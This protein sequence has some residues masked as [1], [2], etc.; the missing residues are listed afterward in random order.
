M[1]ILVKLFEVLLADGHWV[2]TFGPVLFVVLWQVS[3]MGKLHLDAQTDQRKRHIGRLIQNKPH[4]RYRK[5]IEPILNGIDRRLTPE[6]EKR[7]GAAQVAWS[8]GL[9]QVIAISAF[10]YPVLSAIA[11]WVSGSAITFGAQE[12]LAQGSEMQ[13]LKIGALLAVT[14]ALFLASE[15]SKSWLRLPSFVFAVVILLGAVL[16]ADWLGIPQDIA[17]AFAF[18]AVTVTA[19][20]AAA[21]TATAFV[22]AFVAATAAAAAFAAATAAAFAAAGA[23]AAAF[24]AVLVAAGAGAAAAALWAKRMA[25]RTDSTWPLVALYNAFLAI[26][27]TVMMFNPPSSSPA[28]QAYPLIML[29]LLPLMNTLADFA[30]VGLTRFLLR[31]GLTNLGPWRATLDIIGGAAIFALL[32][33]GAITYFHLVTFS[34][35]TPIF[36]MQTLFDG[37]VSNPGA[38][39]WLGFMLLTTLIPT[40]LHAIIALGAIGFQQPL[41]LRTRLVNLLSSDVETDRAWGVAAYCALWSCAGWAVVALLYAIATMNHGAVIEAIIAA[42]RAYAILIGAVTP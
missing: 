12:V 28:E 26:S 1:E 20:A 13:R 33:C 8:P 11:Q 3:P 17:F 38:Y 7:L 14:S 25:E 24:A 41:W 29:G 40:A 10:A 19:A 34:D 35:G 4:D 23:A 6:G 31:Q 9:F 21:T 16:F 22:A 32:G 30:S 36:D 15:V 5:V 2:I 37:L 42:F 27:A 18:V 39:S